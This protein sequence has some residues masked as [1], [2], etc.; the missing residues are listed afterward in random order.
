MDGVLERIALSDA[1]ALENAFYD[2]K[3]GRGRGEWLGG[4]G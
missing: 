3:G 1:A 4:R 2:L